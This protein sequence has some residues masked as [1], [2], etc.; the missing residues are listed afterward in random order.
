MNK[1]QYNNRLHHISGMVNRIEYV[2]SMVFE[3]KQPR[4]HMLS[5][6]LNVNL[7]WSL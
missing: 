7:L 6:K 1:L 2:Q 3:H 5:I 4:Y